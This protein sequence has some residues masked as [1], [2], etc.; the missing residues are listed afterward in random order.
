MQVGQLS[1]PGAPVNLAKL[2][3]A[4]EREHRKRAAAGALSPPQVDIDR[5][6][7]PKQAALVKAIV[8]GP[9]RS[10][11]A[12]CG[13]QSGKSHGGALASVVVPGSRARVNWIYVTSTYAT[14]RKMAF[15]PAVEHNRVHALAGEPHMGTQ[16]MDIC[17]PNG[18]V[19]YF[20]GADTDRGIERL[21]RGTPN[22]AGCIIDEAGVYD[23]D[24][25]KRMIEAV[26]PGL[27]PLAG[28]LVVMGTPSLAG[29]QGTWYDITENP[30]WDHHRFDYRNND[31]VPSFADVE[32]L[33]DEELAAMGYTRDSAY[34]KREYLAQ[35]EVDLAEKVYQIGEDN[36]VDEL[37]EGCET[38]I[39]GCD[40]GI[41][42]ND[43]IVSLGWNDEARD[44]W[45]M[46]QEEASG[47]DSI[48][49]AHM[50]ESHYRER[51]PLVIDVDPG[52]LGQK[53]IGTV[54]AMF[55]DVPVMEALK[56][57]IGIQVRAVNTLAQGGR[58]KIKRGS[59][60]ALELA[61][62]TWV[63]GIVGGKI[64]EHGRHS[65][66]VP[67]L[68][69]ACLRALRLLPDGIPKPEPDERAKRIAAAQKKVRPVVDE[70]WDDPG[71]EPDGMEMEPGSGW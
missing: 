17:F 61:G 20:F 65:D 69:Y 39:T 4:A 42:A 30:H 37:P 35:F 57:P 36:L 9:A 24:K 52:G 54:R 44:V 23:P 55:P 45:V 41:S 29:K 48:A 56:P 62:P 71:G 46:D 1:H 70:G 68:R 11:D 7:H 18:S 12:L 64:D 53:T 50:V 21:L 5:I 33:I 14:C 67:A 51:H 34:F 58:L 38:F 59:K 22:L 8:G 13:R 2:R 25:L 31:R 19:A 49:S 40:L 63:D 6:C 32:Q 43:A 60:L 47:Q 27:R 3:K 66:L 16:Q 15:L 26:R 28:K 10:I